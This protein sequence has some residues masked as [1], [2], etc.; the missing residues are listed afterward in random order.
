M[1]SGAGQL[2]EP[3]PRKRCGLPEARLLQPRQSDLRRIHIPAVEDTLRSV[4]RQ[5]YHCPVSVQFDEPPAGDRL[6]RSRRE[7]GLEYAL[8]WIFLLLVIGAL[9]WMKP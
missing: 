4:H 8:L 9:I 7:M 5:F 6:D 3:L 1:V 2:C